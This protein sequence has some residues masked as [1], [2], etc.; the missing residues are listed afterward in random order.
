MRRHRHSKPDV[1][2][3]CGTEVP[4]EAAACPEC[5]SD[6]QT[7]WSEQA[8]Y[9]SLDLP[10]QEFDYDDFV[11]REFGPDQARSPRRGWVWWVA[12]GLMLAAL[13]GFLCCASCERLPP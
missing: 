13:I 10:N 9:D 7:G 8:R 11:A 2:P 6:E 4:A 12:I 1:C 3:Q 5:G